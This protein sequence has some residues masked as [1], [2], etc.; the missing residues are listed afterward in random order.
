[1]ADG[2]PRAKWGGLWRVH[3]NSYTFKEWTTYFKEE[4]LEVVDIHFP[5]NTKHKLLNWQRALHYAGLSRL[6]ERLLRMGIPCEVNF[7]LQKID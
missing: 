2:E 4:G 3:E 5:R 1:M 6:P 7:V